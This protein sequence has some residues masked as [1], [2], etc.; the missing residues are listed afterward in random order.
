MGT[1][2]RDRS[3]YAPWKWVHVVSPCLGAY[4]KWS[5]ILHFDTIDINEIGSYYHFDTQKCNGDA[6]YSCP[7]NQLIK[8][9]KQLEFSR[10]LKYLM[11]CEREVQYILPIAQ[12]L[13]QTLWKLHKSN[14]IFL[15]IL[16]SH[17]TTSA[18]NDTNHSSKFNIHIDTYSKAWNL[19]ISLIGSHDDINCEISLSF[20][21]Q[22]SF[23]GTQE[24]Y[25]PFVFMF[26]NTVSGLVDTTTLIP[27]GTLLRSAVVIGSAIVD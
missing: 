14:P 10:K 15:F 24:W 22:I 21:Y 18:H 19:Y 26:S 1:F 25:G 8:P 7:Y 16:W 27:H 4:T 2:C 9:Y 20:A 12:I 3:V 6:I 5:L 13:T 17:C 11:I 23:R